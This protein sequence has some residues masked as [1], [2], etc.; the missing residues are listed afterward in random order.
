MPIGRN[1][2]RLSVQNDQLV[3]FHLAAAAGAM[4]Y[5][6]EDIPQRI[7]DFAR[8]ETV[9]RFECG[10]VDLAGHPSGQRLKFSGERLLDCRAAAG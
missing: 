7:F 9:G 1:R 3:T 10:S 8:D 4:K 2:N 6:A 5:L